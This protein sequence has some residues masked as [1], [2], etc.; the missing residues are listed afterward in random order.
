MGMVE[1]RRSFRGLRK[2]VVLAVVLFH[3]VPGLIDNLEAWEAIFTSESVRVAGD[4]VVIGSVGLCVWAPRAVLGWFI[5]D[6]TVERLAISAK[7]DAD[8]QR[9]VAM[10]D[11]RSVKFDEVEFSWEEAFMR[12]AP[13]IAGQRQTLP[14]VNCQIIPETF[15]HIPHGSPITAVANT[16]RLMGQWIALGLVSLKRTVRNKRYFGGYELTTLGMS[17]YGELH[18]RA[19]RQTA[20]TKRQ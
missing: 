12:V 8:I 16:E 20:A 11:G 18:S 19:M 7:A 3:Q 5:G 6:E 10:I 1:H 15:E 14:E 17:V 13:T 4:L 9:A 2:F